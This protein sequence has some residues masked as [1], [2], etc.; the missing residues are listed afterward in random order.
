MAKHHAKK[1][2]KKTGPIDMHNQGKSMLDKLAHPTHHTENRKTEMHHGMDGGD[3]DECGGS[4]HHLDC[5][6][7]HE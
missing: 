2:A 4:D 5:N 3:M 7:D 1:G 6:E